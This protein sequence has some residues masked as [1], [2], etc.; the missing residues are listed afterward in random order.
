M[1]AEQ[2]QQQHDSHREQLRPRQPAPAPEPAPAAPAP[3]RP[4]QPQ[5]PALPAALAVQFVTEAAFRGAASA[6]PGAVQVAIAVFVERT[7]TILQA[8]EAM[9]TTLPQPEITAVAAEAMQQPPGLPGQ[10]CSH[11]PRGIPHRLPLQ[12][13][14]RGR[15]GR[16]ASSTAAA[17]AALAR[18]RRHRHQKQKQQQQQQQRAERHH[19]RQKQI[20][21]P[22]QRAERHHR[23]QKQK[24]Q[25]QQAVT[26]TDPELARQAHCSEYFRRPLRFLRPRR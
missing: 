17:A 3:A 26:A 24:Q 12:L 13:Q 11:S 16:R 1:V 22:Q 5:P 6:G 8:A 9:A 23:H 10:R 18:R 19:R 4:P 2:A 20:Q 25:Q 21:Q 15:R 7:T 14:H